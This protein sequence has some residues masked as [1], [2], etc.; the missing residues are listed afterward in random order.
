[1]LACF[2]VHHVN[3]LASWTNCVVGDLVL[4]LVT[5]SWTQV[6]CYSWPV[7]W[8][9]V[10]WFTRTSTSHL[11]QKDVLC[12]PLLDTV[13]APVNKLSECLYCKLL[14][15]CSAPGGIGSVL[16]TQV[17]GSHYISPQI[18]PP[19]I[20]SVNVPSNPPTY[21]TMGVTRQG[22]RSGGFLPSPWI[23]FPS[24]LPIIQLCL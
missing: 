1:M 21:R 3:T 17:E 9:R 24:S 4:P 10:R 14:F 22:M 5:P 16:I 19:F 20:S 8:F 15:F 12:S 13:I 7:H 23:H 11:G 2:T 6:S 18:Y